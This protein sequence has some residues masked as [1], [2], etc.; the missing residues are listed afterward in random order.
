MAAGDTLD[1]F[2]AL[3]NEPPSASFATLDTR[4]QH[5]VL[6]FDGGSNEEAVFRGIMPQNYDGGGLDVILHVSH[7][8]DI[9]NDT[10]WDAQFERTSDG[11]LD[12]DGD[13][14][15]AIQSTDGTSVP[16]TAGIIQ[17]ITVS[18]TAGQIDGITAGDSY[19]LKV[20]RDAV[21]DASTTDAEL[22]AVEVREN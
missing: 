7:S 20:I 19:R 4:N 17:K 3:H 14:F 10:D 15:A 2:T 18:F 22:S 21:S 11:S 1:K 5:P 9:T 16:G 6:D 12:I 8:S 13:G